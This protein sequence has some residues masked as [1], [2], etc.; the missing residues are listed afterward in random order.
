MI[1]I[2]EEHPVHVSQESAIRGEAAARA[3]TEPAERVAAALVVLRG[4][5]PQ[6]RDERGAPGVVPAVNRG[7]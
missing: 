5:L 3:M 7:E 2:V 1:W 6:H 4:E